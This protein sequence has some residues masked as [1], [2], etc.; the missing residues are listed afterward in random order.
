MTSVFTG[1]INL[2]SCAPIR[3]AYISA[4][5][6]TKAKVW[7]FIGL[8]RGAPSIKSNLSLA[9]D[10]VGRPSVRAHKRTPLHH[11]ASSKRL[12]SWCL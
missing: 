10:Q 3:L 2:I 4:A 5:S 9:P 12:G 7:P 6:C 1:F 11:T 8:F